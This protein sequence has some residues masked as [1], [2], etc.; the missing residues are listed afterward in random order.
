MKKGMQ[1]SKNA[2]HGKVASLLKAK[3][4]VKFVSANVKMACGDVRL[5]YAR[6]FVLPG[7]KATTKL[8]MIRCLISM[9]T[10]TMSLQKEPWA[11][12]IAS[13]STLRMYLVA[14]AQSLVPK[15]LLSKLV[16]ELTKKS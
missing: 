14:Q 9:E 3:T 4:N 10:V 12:L 16:P 2:T 15:P 1:S 11:I 8:L 7:E 6:V 5:E 13:L